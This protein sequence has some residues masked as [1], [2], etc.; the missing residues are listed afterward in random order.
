VVK[1]KRKVD[2]VRMGAKLARCRTPL[3]ARWCAFQFFAGRGRSRENAVLA[4]HDTIRVVPKDPTK[5]YSNTRPYVWRIG[6]SS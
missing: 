3:T 2:A 1:S 4:D 5:D 6:K